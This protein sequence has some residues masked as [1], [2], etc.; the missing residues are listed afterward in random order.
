M[1][2][3]L[4]FGLLHHWNP[5]VIIPTTG[6][7]NTLGMK[8][9]P[10]VAKAKT[11]TKPSRFLELSASDIVLKFR[12]SGMSFREMEETSGIPRST[13]CRVGMGEVARVNEDH[14]RTLYNLA[15][16]RGLI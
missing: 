11:K 2:N 10:M 9:K 7:T 5:R 1:Q 16:D 13:L 6:R 15:V 3:T 4:N 14:Y 8:V 12:D